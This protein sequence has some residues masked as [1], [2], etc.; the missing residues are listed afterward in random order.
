MNDTYKPSGTTIAKLPVRLSKDGVFYDAKNRRLSD[1]DLLRLVNRLARRAERGRKL[2][3]ESLEMYD[4]LTAAGRIP[5]GIHA[6]L[7]APFCKELN[8]PNDAEVEWPEKTPFLS[9]RCVTIPGL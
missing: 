3:R 4:Y 2:R 7:W 6:Q 9:G 1:D 8:E 5:S